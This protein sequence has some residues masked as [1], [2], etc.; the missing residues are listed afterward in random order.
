MLLSFSSN[1]PLLR[2]VTQVSG[3]RTLSYSWLYLTLQRRL[4]FYGSDW[5]RGYKK[6]ADDALASVHGLTCR[7]L[8]FFRCELPAI[9]VQFFI[10]SDSLPLISSAPCAES[11]LDDLEQAEAQRQVLEAWVIEQEV[12]AR[13]HIASLYMC[14]FI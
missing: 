9:R 10:K 3:M 12:R 2:D 7:L 8:L 13:Q 5:V 1:A 11:A 6:A 4:I 14:S